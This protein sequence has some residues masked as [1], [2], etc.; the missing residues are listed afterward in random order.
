MVHVSFLTMFCPDL[1]GASLGFRWVPQRVL[2]ALAMPIN[3]LSLIRTV[4]S[5]AGHL[6][7]FW[8]AGWYMWMGVQM[9]ICVLDCGLSIRQ[10]NHLFVQTSQDFPSNQ[11]VNSV[12]EK[13]K[14]QVSD[15]TGWG[16]RDR[17]AFLFRTLFLMHVGV[18][19][20]PRICR[21][22]PSRKFFLW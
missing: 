11:R 7:Y 3:V 18:Y 6:C 22:R 17:E 19:S 13:R 2:T 5:L 14:E 9:M 10:V 12:T 1:S 4:S 16:R 21:H 20:C 8:G 15:L